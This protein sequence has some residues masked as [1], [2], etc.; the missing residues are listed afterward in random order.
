M[1]P[2]LYLG[3]SNYS[4]AISFPGIKYSSANIE[5]FAC[6]SPSFHL[7][8]DPAE[9]Y[10]RLSGQVIGIHTEDESDRL[11]LGYRRLE[12]SESRYENAIGDRKTSR[13]ALTKST[14]YDF[15]KQS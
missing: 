11:A 8:L 12:D 2:C 6:G 3:S 9:L 1:N 14:N 7:R 10:T 4:A 5:P 13:S 15:C